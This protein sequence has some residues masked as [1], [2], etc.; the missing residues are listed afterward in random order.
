[1][2]PVVRFKSVIPIKSATG[3]TLSTIMV[4]VF[5]NEQIPF[6]LCVV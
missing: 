4:W 3:I 2:V 6:V 1:M 5:V